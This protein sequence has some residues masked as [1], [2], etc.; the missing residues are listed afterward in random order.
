M[1]IKPAAMGIT[2]FLTIFLGIGATMLAEVWTTESSKVPAKIQTGKSAGNYNPADIR[3]S[4]TFAEVS[5][6]FEIDLEILYSAFGIPKS[7]LG[8]EIQ[9]KDLEDMYSG[10]EQEIGNESVQV[11][12]ALYKGLPVTL[13]DE[14]LPKSAVDILLKDGTDLTDEQKEYLSTH[15]I[16]I[17]KY[18]VEGKPALEN[19]DP[20]SEHEESGFKITG[21]T[22]FNEVIG[23]G[24]LKE[25]IESI[26]GEPIPAVNMSVKD[27]CVEKGKSF[28]EIK[29]KLNEI[30]DSK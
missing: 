28:S 16:D 15:Y 1:K 27:Y 24:V 22:T 13:S 29:D 7:T 9:T 3:G 30:I 25:D 2:I 10:L 26:I 8:S 23:Q 11:F 21:A 20:D 4:Y 17:D 14:Y 6:L 12:V 19:T 18:A 5:E